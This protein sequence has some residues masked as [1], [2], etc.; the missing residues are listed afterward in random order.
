M[1]RCDVTALR[2]KTNVG[3]CGGG[4]KA[5]RTRSVSRMKLDSLIFF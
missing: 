4:A 5:E 1:S 2:T 3:T